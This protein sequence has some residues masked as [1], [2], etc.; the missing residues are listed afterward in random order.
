MI[1]LGFRDASVP[2]S[3][4]D[5]NQKPVGYAL[6]ICYRIADAVKERLGLVKLDI[7]LNAVTSATRI[8]LIASQTASATS[9]A[10]VSSSV[11]CAQ[12]V[13]RTLRW[14]NACRRYRGTGCRI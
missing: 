4:L 9:E 5:G 12:F 10:R 13:R 7:C 14:S 3:F 6:D 8:P 11:A 1:T 2:L